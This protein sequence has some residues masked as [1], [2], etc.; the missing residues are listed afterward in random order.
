M[1]RDHKRISKYDFEFLPLFSVRWTHS[2]IFYDCKSYGFICLLY[3]FLWFIRTLVGDT[4]RN[5]QNLFEWYATVSG[6][7]LY[8]TDK[9]SECFMNKCKYFSIR[10]QNKKLF[11][12]FCIYILFI[13]KWSIISLVCVGNLFIYCMWVDILITVAPTPF[14][15][16]LPLKATPLVRSLFHRKRGCLCIHHYSIFSQCHTDDYAVYYWWIFS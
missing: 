4:C 2:F 16:Q 9:G 8:C 7:Y 10:N 11:C 12:V 1:V 15:R 6:Y 5:W 14:I 13:L 3:W